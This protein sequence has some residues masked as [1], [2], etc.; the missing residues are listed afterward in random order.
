MPLEFSGKLSST[1][2]ITSVVT[3]T[4]RRLLSGLVLTL[5]LA[6]VG[7]ISPKMADQPLE[8]IPPFTAQRVQDIR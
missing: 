1:R 3:C 8:N 2:S 5:R 7:K 4:S 6:T